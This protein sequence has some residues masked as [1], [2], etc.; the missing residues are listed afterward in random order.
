MRNLIRFFLDPYPY[1]DYNA[2]L[3]TSASRSV[4]HQMEQ[5]AIVL[6]ENNGSTLPINPKSKTKIAVIGPQANRV[7]VSCDIKKKTFVCLHIGIARGLRLLQCDQQW[8]FPF[9]WHHPIPEERVFI[10]NSLVF[11]RRRALVL[12]YL[13]HLACSFDSARV[14]RR[15]HPRRYMVIGPDASMDPRNERDHWRAC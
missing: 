2:T 12:R 8:N 13:A 4:L 10:R 5:E 11:S 15:N 1:S 7:S 9:G 14:R 6:L 3:R